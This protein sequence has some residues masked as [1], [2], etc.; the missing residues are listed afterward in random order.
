K[1]GAIGMLNTDW[2]DDGEALQGYRWH[3]HAWGAECA[4]NASTTSPEDFN[5]RI[6][7]VLF[8]E[9]GDHF[10]QAIELLAQ[11]HELPG[12]QGMQNRRFWENDFQPNRSAAA[13]RKSSDRL[14]ELVRPAIE[15]LEACR[16]QASVNADLLDAFLHGARRMELIGTRMRDGFQAAQLYAQAVELPPR[17]SL[18]RLDQIEPLVRANR[19]AHEALGREFERLWRADCKPYALDWTMDRYAAT[20][21]WYD[22][23][24]EQLAAARQAAQAGQPL[25]PPET[26]G[27]ALPD[28]FA[29]RTRPHRIEAT[30]L[31]PDAPWADA[32]ATSR[33]GLVVKAG[34][35]SR[36]ELPIELDVALPEGFTAG[37]AR[38]FCAAGAGETQEILVQIDPSEAAGK[39]RLTLLIPGPIAAGDE[40]RVHV[41]FGRPSPAPPLATAVST[42]DA[43][44]GMHWIENDQ[45]RLLLGSEGA[46]LYRWEV[47]SL[48][49]RDLTQPGERDWAGFAD[50]GHAGRN[51]PNT[52]VCTKRGPALV[53]FRCTD[54]TGLEKVINC[55]GGTSWVEVILNEPVTYYWDFD[56]PANFAADGPAPGEYLFS[57]GQGGPV[58]KQADGV[59]A[60]VKAAGVQWAVKFHHDGLALG[61]V[62]PDQPGSFCVAPGAGAGGVGIESSPP[63][64]HFVTFGGHLTDE[65]K[66]RMES[67][68]QTLAFRNQPE[69]V[70]YAVES[71]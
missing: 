53:Q 18:P 8:G 14:L 70:L 30:P 27:I 64:S 29:R 9:P 39:V 37:S 56:N 7:A 22:G 66:S 42:G 51:L 20:V 3:G 45:L 16:Q 49:G 36:A 17:E 12:M 41:Y 55:F 46:H 58:G 5:R 69:V 61:L 11:T 4:W 67:L 71:K 15:H 23:V 63:I 28:K 52:L 65:P 68:R 2:E 21:K 1:H 54:E 38:A 26:V 31:A 47:K 35:V 59:K 6:G 40:N 34:G 43:E 19:D 33:L 13:I 44:G 10:G 25:P 48:G 50:A 60:Q 57:N 24:L 62:S 32:E